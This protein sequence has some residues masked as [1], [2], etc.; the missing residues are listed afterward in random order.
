MAPGLCPVPLLPHLA[1]CRTWG[2]RP[3]GN[4]AGPGAPE[5]PGAAGRWVA[6]P[7]PQGRGATSPSAMCHRRGPRCGCRCAGGRR[8]RAARPYLAISAPPGPHPQP[9]KPRPGQSRPARPPGLSHRP[10]GGWGGVTDG[11]P[12]ALLALF[13]QRGRRLAGG[14]KGRGRGGT[15]LHYPPPEVPRLRG[16]SGRPGACGP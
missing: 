14:T 10:G 1:G 3:K 13:S 8:R 9:G 6:S 5:I 11:G 2:T 4:E 15:C 12:G 7:P 16:G